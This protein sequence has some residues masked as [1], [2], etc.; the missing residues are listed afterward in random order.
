[1][2]YGFCFAKLQLFFE[3]TKFFF[4]LFFSHSKFFRIFAK[5]FN[6]KNKP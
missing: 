1:M 4:N 2:Q 6:Q 3:L 5:H